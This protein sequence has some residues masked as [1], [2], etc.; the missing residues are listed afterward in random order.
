MRDSGCLSVIIKLI[1]V[2]QQHRDA[3]KF[4]EFCQRFLVLLGI[5]KRHYGAGNTAEVCECFSSVFG[6]GIATRQPKTAEK[7]T[8]P[9]QQRFGALAEWRVLRQQQLQAQLV[10]G[11]LRNTAGKQ[12]AKGLLSAQGDRINRIQAELLGPA[13]G[14]AL[15]AATNVS[16]QRT[17]QLVSVDTQGH[18]DQRGLNRF[19]GG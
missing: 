1:V 19:E 5:L 7:A 15:T 6:L 3:D 4:D 12:L 17:V 2:E 8:A 11:K 16:T 9:L 18:G 13:C 14:A 10:I